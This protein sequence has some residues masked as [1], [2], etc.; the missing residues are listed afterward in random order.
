MSSVLILTKYYPFAP[1]KG[2]SEPFL[3][4]EVRA[5][6]EKFDEVYIMASYA[7][8]SSRMAFDVPGN[9]RVVPLALPDTKA[10]KVV[11]ALK[12]FLMPFLMSRDHQRL[13]SA[14]A[15]CGVKG[16]IYRCY[17]IQRADN[18]FAAVRRVLQ[19][20]ECPAFDVVY[21]YWLYETALVAVWMKREFG[22]RRAVSRAHGY[23]VYEYR[24]PFNYIPLRDY[25]F[26]NLDSVLVCSEDGK[27]YLNARY[28][29]SSRD[30]VKALHLGVEGAK[31]R[32]A[33]SVDKSHIV[34]VSC[35]RVYPLKRIDLL[36]DALS[37]LDLQGVEVTWIHYGDGPDYDRLYRATQEIRGVRCLMLGSVDH[38]RIIDDYSTRHFDLFINVSSSEGIPVSIMEACSAGIPILATDVGGVRE[39]VED[40]VNGILVDVGIDAESLAERIRLFLDLDAK[41]I[42]EWRARSREIW[43][44]SFSATGNCA[45]LVR[46]LMDEED[47][48]G[49]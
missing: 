40:G 6:S 9:V 45:E 8:Q 37:A 43:E 20:G 28:P 27:R 16:A 25:L 22:V 26:D 38:N 17:F 48:C 47:A 35:S 3:E 24:N 15:G 32:S 39:I 2:V 10:S 41:T 31:D 12:G 23:D 11:N 7:G 5:V 36:V 30:V 46:V 34:L 44:E 29:L 19:E 42:G 1:E 49:R 14:D 33:D 18:L 13:R 21:S 4:P